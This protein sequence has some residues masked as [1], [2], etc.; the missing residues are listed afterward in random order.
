MALIMAG[1]F[2]VY[3]GFVVW[4]GWDFIA[5][6][7]PGGYRAGVGSTDPAGRG[8]RSGVA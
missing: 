5:S 6:G 8:R 2:F 1:L 7:E 3:A 4:R